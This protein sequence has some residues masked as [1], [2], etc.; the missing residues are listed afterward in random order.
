MAQ[1]IDRRL[2]PRDKSLGNR[3]R[4]L[5][6]RAVR[7]QARGRQ[8]GA[9]A[10]HRRRR[11][12]A[13]RSRSRPTAS[14][15]RSSTFRATSGEREFV[16]PGNKEFVAGDTHRQARRAV[17][18]GGGRQGRRTGRG[19]DAF[20]FALTEAEFLDILFEDLELPDLVKTSLKDAKAQ[21]VPPRRLHERRRDAQ[22]RRAAH[23]AR[24]HGPAA[25][26]APA[27][28]GRGPEA[29]GRTRR[30]ARQCRRRRSPSGS[31][32]CISRARSS[33]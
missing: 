31:A 4:F 30:A 6:R 9:R 14:T 5:R 28:R 21:G 25:G 12:R 32:S 19:E 13:A 16:L 24:Q 20:S 22:S 27:E 2:N 23:D 15:S 3:Q 10:H 17:G 33:A 1:F 29:R 26:A 7:G 8:G 18:G 11:A